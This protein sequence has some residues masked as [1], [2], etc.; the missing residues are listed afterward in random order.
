[1][2]EEVSPAD[3]VWPERVHKRYTRADFKTC[4]GGAKILPESRSAGL[5]TA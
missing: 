5:K 2:V 1:M 4:T 3:E